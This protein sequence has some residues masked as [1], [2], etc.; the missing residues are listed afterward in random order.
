MSIRDVTRG[1]F[2]FVSLKTYFVTIQVSTMLTLQCC[3]ARPLT[4][5]PRVLEAKDVKD[6]V[7]LFSNGKLWLTFFKVSFT[8][9]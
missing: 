2:N 9:V 5:D 4:K 7:H 3:L 6:L 1:K 8:Q